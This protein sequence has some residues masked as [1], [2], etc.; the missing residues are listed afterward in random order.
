MSDLD[1]QSKHRLVGASIWLLLLVIIVPTWYSNPVNFSPE[2]EIKPVHSSTLPTIEHAYRL[3]N[4][5]E[6]P[7]TNGQ[8]KE[9]LKHQNKNS[10]FAD[11]QNTLEKPKLEQIKAP[12]LDKVSDNSRYEGQWIVRLQA[13]N[14]TKQANK[15]ASNLQD[16]Y[17]VYIKYFPKTRVYSVRTGPYVSRAKAEKAKQK[18]DKILRTD[19]V[20]RQLPKNP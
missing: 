9:Y 6:K 17:A 14:N 19:G 1:Q 2:G 12:F 18:L 8:T 11:Q 13:F 10:D 3:P 7:T 15:L 20:I 4:N 16:N 5:V